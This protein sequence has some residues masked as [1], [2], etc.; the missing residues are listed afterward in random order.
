MVRQYSHLTVEERQHF[1]EH[2]WLRVPNAIKTEYLDG[3]M[4]HLWTRLGMDPNDK[5]T[6][7]YEYLK[8][9]RHREVRTDEFCPKAWAKICEIV[10]GEDLIDPVRD[11]YYGDQFHVNFGKAEYVGQ[12]WSRDMI[13]TLHHD[14]DFFRQFLDS[15]E[16]PLTIICAFT[17]MDEERG[18][19]VV[20]EEGLKQ[21][22][23]TFYKHPEGIDP[24]FTQVKPYEGLEKSGKYTFMTA[25]AGDVIITH[26]LLPHAVNRN[27]KHFARVIT[28]P[29]V[30]LT[31][32]LQLAREDGDYT[33]VEQVIL[34]HMGRDS[35]PEYK[36]TRPRLS[37]YP[38]EG[39]CKRARVGEELERM[40]EEAKRNNM[41][42]ESVG[43]I[44]QGTPEEIAEHERRNGYDK[45]WGPNGVR[46]IQDED[47]KSLE[48]IAWGKQ[49]FSY[50]D[51]AAAHL[52][53]ATTTSIKA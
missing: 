36:A 48:G 3:W 50:K 38:R 6:W 47:H 45:D 15:G 19:T 26:D 31:Q 37:Y 34:H 11:R 29:H 30:C 25:K 18:A 20:C 53:K 41:P 44:Y 51:T 49:V 23:E 33:L 12:P 27:R 52:A 43:S 2:G 32:P 13:R 35:I 4:S 17:D 28:N 14:N 40:I 10:G 16:C 7:N 42:P 46:L 24:P 39:F 1:V 5:S 9:P 8:M 22:C 21:V